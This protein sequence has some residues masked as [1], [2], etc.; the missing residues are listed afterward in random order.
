MATADENRVML[1]GI[2][3][4]SRAKSQA[5]T[6]IKFLRSLVKDGEV[7]AADLRRV[8]ILYDEARSDVNA[9]LD[10]LLAELEAT[11]AYETPEPF[12][13]VAEQAGKR[14]AELI[15]VSDRLALGEDRGS[16]IEAGVKLA[17][18]LVK[19]FVDV[20]KT[21]RGERTAR[22]SLLLQRIGSLK[23]SAFDDI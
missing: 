13:R 7:D 17:D 21:L 14:V 22:R 12:T 15:S 9:G 16:P 4:L 19:A 5:E 6:R 2:E 11:G 10:R 1:D 8:R 23:W 18:T 3:V 20:W